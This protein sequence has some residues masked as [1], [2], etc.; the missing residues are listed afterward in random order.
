MLRDGLSDAAPHGVEF[1]RANVRGAIDVLRETPTPRVL[2]V[3]VSG[4]D[5]PLT[6][7]E[8]LSDVVEPD[9]HVLLIGECNDVNFYRHAT[10]I[11][12]VMEYLFKP[13][14]RDM[15]ARHFGPVILNRRAG[16]KPCRADA[17]SRSPACAAAS[18]PAPSRPIWPGISASGRIATPCCWTPICTAAAAR[19]C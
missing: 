5:R 6:A 13:I 14:T 3:D 17:S 7:L 12:G 8:E 16:R 11:L 18:V 9:V 19:C 15:V 2:I 1:H 10:R 4:E